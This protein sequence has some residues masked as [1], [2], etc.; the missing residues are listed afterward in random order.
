M[1][2]KQDVY[3]HKTRQR[4][5]GI[6]ALLLTL[7][8]LLTILLTDTKPATATTP[9]TG[10]ET[11]TTYLPMIMRNGSD[12]GQFDY[13]A[14]SDANIV[15]NGPALDALVAAQKPLL[16]SQPPIPVNAL[17]YEQARSSAWVYLQQRVG[18]ANLTT[19]RGLPE[20]ATA[21]NAQTFAMAAAVDNRPDG[22]L[23]GLLIAYEKDPSD[24][25]ILVN[26]AGVFNL[27]GMPNHALAFLNQAEDAVGDLADT[28]N[29]P[30]VQVAANNR[31][32][33]HISLGQW[34][35][36]EAL[37]RPLMAAHTE[38]SEARQSLAVALLCQNKDEEAAHYYRLGARRQWVD[39]DEEI[40]G[41]LPLAQIYDLSAGETPTLPPMELP[42]GTSGLADTAGYYQGVIVDL[43]ADGN[44]MVTQEEIL[45]E[46]IEDRRADEPALTTFRFTNIVSAITSADQEPEMLALEADF[47]AAENNL[48]E[49]L[50]R[51]GDEFVELGDQELDPVVYFSACRSLLTNQWGQQQ[52][53]LQAYADARRTHAHAL[54]EIETG[55]AANL[56][57]P[58]H[59]QYASLLAE[60]NAK[61]AQIDI[62]NTTATV[63]GDMAALWDYCEGFRADAF[64]PPAAPTLPSSLECPPFVRGAKGSIKLGDFVSFSIAC[65][66]VELEVG[67]SGALGYFSQITYHTRQ[68]SLTVFAGAK[69]KISAYGLVE[70]SAKEGFYIK[71]TPRGQITDVGLKVSTSGAISNGLISGKVDGPGFEFSIVSGAIN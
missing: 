58:L 52:D 61:D 20:V 25:M 3:D 59:H 69:Q 39:E 47:A 46:Q 60:A 35:A 70:L 14:L 7:I 64:P 29:I 10:T 63:T 65:E 16:C 9:A 57:D 48:A 32:H 24:P 26:T 62:V 27:L 5:T 50:N 71:A 21:A 1:T 55:L 2:N 37:L 66:K 17:S 6:T 19:F 31:A 33:A 8:A 36:A 56:I 43:M 54:Y 53:A 28:M 51:H 23:A 49:M 12:A 67:T 40:N 13:L 18:A 4:F 11:Y 41:R 34:A 44:E 45:I 42:P 22:A 30:G 68:V 15:P 38:L